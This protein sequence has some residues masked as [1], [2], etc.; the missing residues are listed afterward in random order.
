MTTTLITGASSG[1][2]KEFAKQLAAAGHNLILVARNQAALEAQAEEARS[3]FGVQAEVIVSDLA[4]PGAAEKLASELQKRSLSVDWLVNN[5]GF[6]DRGRFEALGLQRQSDMIQVNVNALV[7]LTHVMLPKIKQS[8]NGA[9]IN[10]ASTAAFQAGPNM[11]V[12][13]ATKAFVL[14]FSEAL[15]EELKADGV[16]VVCLCPGATETGFIQEANMGDTLLFRAGAMH[17]TPVVSKAIDAVAKNKTIVIPGVKNKLGAWSS[18][19]VPRA[20]TRKIA[21]KLQQ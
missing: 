9:V 20:A 5:A 13:Y 14:S 15:H 19:V 8:A 11:A 2:G 21:A 1:I 6:G 10:V 7:E 16:S 17:V 4:Q 12:Y 18:H 3:R